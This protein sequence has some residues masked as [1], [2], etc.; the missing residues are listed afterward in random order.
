MR[1]TRLVVPPRRA[2]GV[3]AAGRGEDYV[4]DAEDVAPLL[5]DGAH[6]V[7]H[8]YGALVAML[9]AAARPDAV[10]SLTLVEPPA[11]RAAAGDPDAALF[12]AALERASAGTGS[13]REFLQ[14]FR[15]AVGAS[16]E[17]FPPEMPDVWTVLTPPLRYGRPAWQAEVP[18]DR[19]V[20]GS[21]P[22]LVV[23]GNHHRAFE[24][25]CDAL[26][27]DLHATAPSSRARG[28]QSRWSPNRSTPS[29]CAFGS[30]PLSQLTSVV[31]KVGSEQQFSRRASVSSTIVHSVTSTYA[32]RAGTRPSS[33][34]D[35]PSHLT[36][37]R[38]AAGRRPGQ[39]RR[40]NTGAEPAASV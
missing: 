8:S 16:A 28:T 1:V 36:V 31:P 35:S 2:F 37:R 3:G 34:G 6:L 30:A 38:R 12:W 13:D 39:F 14:D 4:T 25:I 29:S 27:R 10:R 5:G 15:R 17:A 7:G 24:A 23:L 11:T 40:Q 26:T 32:C 20:A 22:I 33:C 9:V 19:L 21:F 18:V